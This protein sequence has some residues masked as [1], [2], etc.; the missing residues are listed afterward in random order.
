MLHDISLRVEAGETAAFVGATGSGK[1][2][3]ISLLPRLHEPPPGT[4]LVDGVDVREI[5][6]ARLRGAIGYVPQEP[7]LFSDTIAGN[8]RFAGRDDGA[9]GRA[10]G[11]G[12]DTTLE[13]AA[14]VARLDK[15]V[16]TF[17]H[18]YETMVGERGI[19]LSGG[20]KQRTAI[21]RAISR[22]SPHPGARRCAVGGGHL[23]GRRDPRPAA[24]R[25]EPAHVPDR[26]APHLDRPRRRPDL[27]AGRGPHRRARQ[28]TTTSW[29]STVLYAV[30]VTRKQL[31]EEELDEAELKGHRERSN[32]ES[33]RQGLRRAADAAPAR[34]TCVR[35][36]RRCSSRSGA[37]VGA[38]LLELAQPWLMKIAIDDYIAQ[39]SLEGL[40]RLA[41]AFLAMLVGSF[42]LEYLQTWTL[43]NDRAA[44]HVRH[45]HAGLRPPA[46][47][48][49][50]VL[51][52]QP[53]RPADDARH[54]R[55]RR[56]QRA[57]HRRGRL[58]VRRR[59]RARR[60]H[61][62]AGL[63]GLAARG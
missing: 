10:I 8:I 5:P 31:L 3:L 60:D 43:Q 16:A 59:V 52:P 27:R 55:R 34:R 26:G 21:A 22:R 50:P 40:D 11:D 2:T 58:G 9:P 47:D 24:R 32:E 15:D 42:A 4:V 29:R 46:A 51:R 62:R 35:T 13:S 53:R 14:A 6:L 45:A 28:P 33:P 54:D 23:H 18:G 63:D 30:D 49:R 61:G 56:A 12:G 38:S 44:D 57:V 36:G 1:S 7:F 48:R 25:D 37:I 41:L 20:Q 39:G 17:P 19:T